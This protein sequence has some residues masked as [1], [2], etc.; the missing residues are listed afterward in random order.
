MW[1]EV[2]L[3]RHSDIVMDSGGG[4]LRDSLGTTKEFGGRLN[5][6]KAGQSYFDWF[7]FK[8]LVYKITVEH[9]FLRV[10]C[11]CIFGH[12]TRVFFFYVLYLK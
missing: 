4:V 3:K 5:S 8:Q 9:L 2:W 6:F 7:P 10:S 11:G 12:I 1:N